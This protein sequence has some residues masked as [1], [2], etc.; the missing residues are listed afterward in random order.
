[1]SATNEPTVV[2]GPIEDAP[3]RRPK[4]EPYASPIDL[5]RPKSDLHAKVLHQL[6][7]RLDV[8]ERKM[9][10]FYP[11][12]QV[13][14]KALQGYINHDKW[15]K[16]LKH[17][18]DQGY[19][20]VPISVTVPYIFA[21]VHTMVTYLLHAFGGRKPI[22]QLDAYKKSWIE[23]ARNMERVL[24]YNADHTRL[25]RHLHRWF[26]DA[27]TYGVGI[28]RTN[29]NDEFAMRTEFED[30]PQMQLFGTTVPRRSVRVR[31]KRLVYSGN[32]VCAIDPFMFFPDPRVPMH[33]VNTRG[34]FVFWRAFNGYHDV[35]KKEF[36]G[37]YKYVD[38]VSRTLPRA[39]FEG[40]S[41]R[42]LRSDGESTPGLFVRDG[43]L[44][45]PFQEDQGTVEIIP[46]QWG[47]GD[48]EEPEKWL[49]TILNKQQIVQAEPLEMDHGQHPVAVIEPFTMGPSF[50]SMGSVDVLKPFQDLQ[51]WMVNSHMKNVRVAL[52]NMWI[53]DPSAVE[54]GDLKVPGEG[55]IIRLKMAAFGRDIKSAIQQLPVVDVTGSH[56]RDLEIIVRM[57]HMFL[58]L[59]DNLMGLQESG[60]RKTATEVRTAGE[61]GAS[62]LASLA[63]II[64][65]QGM[66]DLV[67]QMVINIQQRMQQGFML[68]LMGEDQKLQEI[69]PEM[70]TGDFHY[71]VH[72]GTLPL[73]R[74]ALMEV[75]QQVA[76]G[77]AQDPQLRQVFDLPKIVEYIAELGGARNISAFKLAINVEGG[78]RAGPMPTAP[79]PAQ[80]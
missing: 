22:I 52:N 70:L 39:N 63:R 17:I 16:Q 43:R 3:A 6:V 32:D 46:K 25:L 54:L 40:E 80:Q 21:C 72:D 19:A 4:A 53:V 2:G 78:P 77:I 11:R 71:P 68:E 76:L 15:E 5:L 44:D 58:G 7:T 31:K 30:V 67:M 37:V 79:V 27:C 51:S 62:R 48:S 8:S 36:A 13:N 42:A 69:G 12:W 23:N 26:W 50:G 24:Q 33:E 18:N 45:Q 34:E 61:A 38:S 55:K 35:K 49:F 47:L 65:A 14:E 60:G 57:G 29:W 66:T 41:V 74:V 64:S 9:A 75:W 10:D 59:N 1:M 56:M 20:P 73:D 28:L